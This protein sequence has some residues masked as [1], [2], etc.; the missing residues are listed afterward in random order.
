VATLASMLLGML[1]GGLL[2]CLGYQYLMAVASIRQPPRADAGGAPATRFA[3]AIPAHNEA[4]VL[5]ATLARLKEQ[6]YPGE[7][8]DVHV[9]AD[10]CSDETA[11]VARRGGALV[12]ER[13]SLPR[14]RKA[15]ALQWLLARILEA[16]PAYDAVA[17]FDA[18]SQV[19]PGFLRAAEGHLRGGARVVQGQHVIS[20]PDDSLLAAMAAVDMRL[21]NR[22]RNQSRR[23]LGFACRL[24]GDAMVFRREVLQA[25]GWQG[26][27]LTEDREYG[28][29]L[30]LRGIR[31]LYVPEAR[32]YGQAASGWKQA[33]PQRLRWYQGLVAMQ[34]RL[35]GRLLAGAVRERSAALLDGAIELLMPSYSFLAALAVAHLALVAGLEVFAPGV[36]GLLGVWGAAGLVV[37]WAA[38]PVVGLA[39]DRAPGWAYRALLLG[40]AYLAWRLWIGVLVRLRGERIGWV[41]TPRREETLPGAEGDTR[42]L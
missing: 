35:A 11:E 7:L 2:L 15:Y 8:V 28:Y 19:D 30:L 21:N 20:N 16:V 6:E 39:I 9:V 23:N 36:E 34:R 40:P 31:A 12:H 18:D 32:S 1:Q 41:R 25:H 27:T 5:A 37:A 26:E 38:Y 24:M 22:L 10:H 33:G 17:V 13:E 3:V 42:V 4:A 14:G 29:E